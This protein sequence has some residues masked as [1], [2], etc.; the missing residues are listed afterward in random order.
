M[1]SPVYWHP[2]IYNGIMKMLYGTYFQDRYKAI[3]EIIP[4]NASITEICA[5]DAYLY[6]NYL[7]KKNI[8]YTGLDINSVFVRSAQKKNISFKQFNLMTDEVPLSDYVIIQASLYQFI[9]NEDIIISKLLASTKKVLII[10]EPVRNLSDSNNPLISFFAKYSANPG[11]NHV[12]NRFN[13]QTLST[14]F[15]KY[16]QLSELNEI[17]GGREMVGVFRK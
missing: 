1:R 9:P 3:A 5:G 13:A 10:A 11:N 16:P 2:V 7:K 15:R 4:D 12:H 6:L 14:C 17:K 8:N